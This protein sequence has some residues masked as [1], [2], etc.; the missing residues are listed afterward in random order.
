MIKQQW[1]LAT[2]QPILTANHSTFD[3]ELSL[4]TSLPSLLSDVE[5]NP[6]DGDLSNI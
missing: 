6:T 4:S 1:Y 5:R 3:R 2:P